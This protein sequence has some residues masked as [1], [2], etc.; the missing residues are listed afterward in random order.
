[1]EKYQ[2]K[3]N[4]RSCRSNLF[5]RIHS[6]QKYLSVLADNQLNLFDEADAKNGNDGVPSNTKKRIADK[7]R[8]SSLVQSLLPSSFF[9]RSS[10]NESLVHALRL[11]GANNLHTPSCRGNAPKTFQ[12]PS[13]LPPPASITRVVIAN[14]EQTEANF[15]C[16]TTIRFVKDNFTVH[17]R[18]TLLPVRKKSRRSIERGNKDLNRKG[19]DRAFRDLYWS[20]I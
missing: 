12:P 17:Q 13:P 4:V 6:A 2:I 16:N 20:R 11:K 10:S 18:L 5:E 8:L 9:S 1:M 19:I 15:P 14:R 3:I 7:R